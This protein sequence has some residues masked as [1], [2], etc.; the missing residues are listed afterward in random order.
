MEHS[1]DSKP[2]GDDDD[3][4]HAQTRPDRSA[5]LQNLL[6]RFLLHTVLLTAVPSRCLF[7]QAVTVARAALSWQTLVELERSLST[8][9]NNLTPEYCTA[10]FLSANNQTQ[11]SS[12]ISPDNFQAEAVFE[13]T[14]HLSAHLGLQNRKM[15]RYSRPAYTRFTFLQVHCCLLPVLVIS[16]LFVFVHRSQ[17]W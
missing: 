15:T 1:E 4:Q 7:R 10:L 13:S 5:P 17:C 2:D 14:V 6:D 16:A 9:E 8:Q 11:C 3:S 12:A